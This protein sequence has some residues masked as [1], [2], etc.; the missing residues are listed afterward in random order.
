MAAAGPLGNYAAVLMLGRFGAALPQEAARQMLLCNAAMM[1][2]NLLPA[3][4]LDGG[5]MAFSVG[6]YLFGVTALAGV[7]TA[8][9]VAAGCAL[10]ALGLYGAMTL[11][12]VNVSALIVGGYLAAC[13]LQSR[14]SLLAENV[15][16]LVQERTQARPAAA[17]ARVYAVAENTPLCRLIDPIGRCPS[18]LLCVQ[19]ERGLRFVSE[20]DVLLRLLEAPQ[21]TIGTLVRREMANQGENRVNLR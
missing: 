21:E 11:H 20:G 10:M 17:A 5:R 18:A 15:Y 8:L 7:L 16:A 13:A 4:P 2:L 12:V 9:G 14:E 6:Y 19:T 3:L 1:L